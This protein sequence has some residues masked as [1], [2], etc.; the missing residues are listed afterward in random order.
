MLKVGLTGGVAS[1]KSTLAGLLSGLGA[2]VCDADLMVVELYRPGRPGAQTVGELFGRGALTPDDGVDRDALARLVLADPEA[3][4]K[5]EEAVHPLVRKSIEGWH[6]A[7]AHA[8]TP[9]AV[10]VVEAALLVET[11]AYRDQDRLVV[12]TAP[13]EARRVWALAAGWSAGRFAQVVAAQLDDAAREA[14]AD[15]VI[16]NDGALEVLERAAR[17]LWSLLQEDAHLVAA[18]KPLPARKQFG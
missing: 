14:V 3:R 6:A 2:A 8:S 4:R 17:D 1:G 16:R 15:Y 12:V 9:P 10:A 11:G 5:L 18:G 13:L 7:L